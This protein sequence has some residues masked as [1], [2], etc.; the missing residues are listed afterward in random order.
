MATLIE[1]LNSA[2]SDR[3]R[4]EGDL[5]AG[6]MAIVCVAHDLRHGR[7]VAL[8]VL[9]PE[10]ALQLGADRFLSE[11]QT[12][13]RLHHPHILPLYDSGTADGLLYYVMPLVEGESLRQRM[14][15]DKAMPVDAA[16][17]IAREVA[18]ALG[19]AHAHDVIHR[20]VKP[21][22][23]M[24]ANG[25][26]LVADFGIARAL[27]A[28]SDERLTQAG[29][30]IGTPTYMSPEQAGG[31]PDVDG[32]SDLYSLGCMLFEMLAG[33]PPFKG[34]SAA[35]ILMQRFTQQPPRLSTRRA[36]VPG[37]IEAAIQRAMARE[38]TDRFEN[39]TAFAGALQA[40][41]LGEPART[42]KSIAVLP[43][44]NMS[45]EPEDEFF[46]D[47]ITEEIINALTQLEGL[48]VAART[49]S[50]A[51]KG[52]QE[53]LRAIAERLGVTT[54]LEGSVRKSGRRLRVTAQ[55]ITAAD[56]YHLWSERYDRELT[57]VF[58]IQDEIASA[59]AAKLRVTL[60]AASGGQ[61]V[62][63][64]TGHLEAYELLLK[65]RVLQTRRGSAIG[66]ALECFEKAVA[67]DPDF[68]EAQAW[69]ADSYR[70]LAVYGHRAASDVMPRAKAAAERAVALDP[71]LAEAHATLALVALLYDRD[72]PRAEAAWKQALDLNPAHV[73]ARSERAIW[74]YATVGGDPE[75]AVA[76]ARLATEND[77][78][79]AWAVGM[80]GLALGL[81]GR[82][83]EALVEARRASEMDPDGFLGRFLMV[84]AAYW[85]GDYAAAIAAGD[86]VLLMSGRHPWA[87]AALA[88]AHAA[89]GDPEGARAVYGELSARAKTGYVQPFWLATAALA[90]GNLDEAVA[91]VRRS[92][93][94]RDPIVL[95]ANRLPEWAPLHQRPDMIALLRDLGLDPSR[96][97][98]GV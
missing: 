36:G 72:F 50:F 42:D 19:Y 55:L 23:I 7:K 60:S 27:R 45:S 71:E 96:V 38:R 53:D 81:A 28:A 93:V 83:A 37:H 15:R 47:G 75:T 14:D 97:P 1:R 48:R 12:T 67:L 84:Q 31:E 85:A 30:A 69:L 51:F 74:W 61:M 20:D 77:P 88:L 58:A 64:G 35:A 73:R 3:Y 92:V 76:E 62:R 34:S 46:S 44:Q 8:K 66:A 10:L 29:L 98:Q 26:A 33:E 63:P 6:G 9:R 80:T 49:S 89:S 24:L 43:F 18:D 11:I 82:P 13:A 87:L 2:L 25:H 68:A 32:R 65:G 52:T 90:I 91:L 94:E 17:T 40:P 4:V 79:N 5:G 95:L 39:V 78:L 86:P 41:A 22:N 54:I 59:I 70:L 21:E 56:G 57:D 16:L